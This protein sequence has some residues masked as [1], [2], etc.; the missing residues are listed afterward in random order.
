MAR[1]TKIFDTY[2]ENFD[3]KK[4]RKYMDFLVIALRIYEDARDETLSVYQSLERTV[5]KTFHP[6]FTSRN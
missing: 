1:L 3:D 6:E 2:I 5:K 4:I